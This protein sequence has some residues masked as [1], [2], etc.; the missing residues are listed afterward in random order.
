MKFIACTIWFALL[1]AVASAQIQVAKLTASD[2]EQDDH[3]GHSVA[4]SGDWLVVGKPWDNDVAAGSGAVYAYLCGGDDW[5]ET[6]KLK[7]SDAEFADFLGWSVAI[8]GWVCVAGAYYE[9]PLGIS[10]AGSAYVFELSG[11][12]W[13]QSAK[14]WASDASPNE[15]FGYA[16]AAS[17]DRLLIGAREDNEFGYVAGAAYVFDHVGPNWVQSAKL[18]ASDAMSGDGFGLSVSLWGDFALVGS[19]SDGPAG[20]EQGAA[21]VFQRFGPVWTQVAKLVNSDAAYQ[22]YFGSAVAIR[23]DLALVTAQHHDHGAISGG[24][25]Y[26]FE[27]QNGVWIET[28][29]LRAHDPIIG[30]N[31]G[32]SIDVRDDV[33]LFG[34]IGDGASAYTGTGAAYIFS[35]SLTGWVEAGKFIANDA[36]SYD[37]LGNSVALSGNLA[38]VGSALDDDVCPSNINCQSGAAYVFEIAPDARQFGHCASSAPCGNIDTHGGCVN[39]TGVGAT[40]AAGGSSS[41]A[42]DELRFE[43]R[44]MQPA[45]S[46]IVFMGAGQGQ[47]VL[48]DGLRVVASA[49]SGFYRYPLHQSDTDGSFVLGPGLVAHSQNFPQ[50]GHLLAGSTWNFQCWYRD[51][52]GPCGQGTN[53]SNAVEVTMTP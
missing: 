18:T 17:G 6:Q 22:D 24:A 49:G 31:F 33:A 47:T 4:S 34:A 12:V 32:F 5:I 46:A 16:V 23:Q 8:D 50:S 13:A 51:P 26:V 35:R 21:Y 44:Q 19:T 7:A 9:S 10:A 28:Q 2:V 37:N 36:S 40:L 38:F 53:L 14:I 20:G 48:G 1:A 45:K 27:R 11:G 41:V 52:A 42:Q 29:E 15:F 3:F 30:H 25:V 39:S 43:V